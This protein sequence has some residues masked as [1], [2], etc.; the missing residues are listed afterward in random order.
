VGV[1][2]AVGL[3]ATGFGDGFTGAGGV[4]LGR[5]SGADADGAVL[6]LGTAAI[7]VEGGRSPLIIIHTTAPPTART[8]TAAAA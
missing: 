7:S 6:V 1:G 3:L 4:G 2:F 8:A 5:E